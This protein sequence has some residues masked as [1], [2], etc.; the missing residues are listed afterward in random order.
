MFCGQNRK[1]ANTFLRSYRKDRT[2]GKAPDSLLKLGMS[3]YQMKETDAAC[4]TLAELANKFP[5]APRHI[6]QRAAEERR[7]AGCKS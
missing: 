3:L 7:R 2:G 5:R 4:A 6:K 1:A